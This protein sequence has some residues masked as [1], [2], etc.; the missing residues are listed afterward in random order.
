MKTI[1]K[2]EIISAIVNEGAKLVKNYGVYPEIYLE[3]PNGNK[4]WR[5][6]K[7]SNN[8][9]GVDGIKSSSNSKGIE[10]TKA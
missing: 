7:G 4:S 3:Y 6:R 10:Y 2:K 8:L 1:T 9:F 5:L